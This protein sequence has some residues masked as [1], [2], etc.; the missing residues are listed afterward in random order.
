MR[1]SRRTLQ[2]LGWIVLVAAAAPLASAQVQVLSPNGGETWQG[3]ETRVISWSAVNH[4]DGQMFIS[5]SWDGG[6]TWTNIDAF[7]FYADDAEGVAH[8]SRPWLVPHVS[9]V[10]CFVKVT[11]QW[12]PQA[13]VDTSNSIF[14]L[15]LGPS[16]S[17]VP[18]GGVHG[19]PLSF[20]YRFPSHPGATAYTFLTAEGTG[21]PW[22]LPGGATLNLVPD[23]LMVL[24]LSSPSVSTVVLDAQGAGS[25][26]PFSIPNNPHLKDTTLWV[27]GAVVPPGSG[28]VEST[29]TESLVIR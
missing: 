15:G 19:G 21:A 26:V 11:Y 25:T 16:T 6:Q 3:G 4:G 7:R 22:T 9:S 1:P 18:L 2:G 23:P 17:V 14:T 13:D 5:L 29:P 27:A 24:L 10:L 28:F 8:F 20:T 12:R